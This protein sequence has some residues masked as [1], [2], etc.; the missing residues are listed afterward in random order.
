MIRVLHTGDL[1]LDSPFRGLSAEKAQTR[2]AEQRGLLDKVAR[3]W[4][5]ERGTDVV[6]IAGGPFRRRRRLLRN[7][8]VCWRRCLAG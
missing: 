6:L 8:P 2:R 7:L 5:E 1:H 4:P 3:C